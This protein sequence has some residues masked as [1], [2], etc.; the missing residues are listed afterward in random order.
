M[1]PLHGWTLEHAVSGACQ[2]TSQWFF[3]SQNKLPVYSMKLLRCVSESRWIQWK[4]LFEYMPPKER[5][6]KWHFSVK[7]IEC[8]PVQ[9][10]FKHHLQALRYNQMTKNSL[11]PGRKADSQI[12]C[13]R[14]FQSLIK[15]WSKLGQGFQDFALHLNVHGKSIHSKIALHWEFT[16]TRWLVRDDGFLK[17]PP[18]L[19]SAK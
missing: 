12:I 5:L 1:Q 17:I 10:C 14:E 8:S 16:A 15:K 9:V 3:T 7:N 4:C 2:C 13:I 6:H 19:S 18:I 11:S